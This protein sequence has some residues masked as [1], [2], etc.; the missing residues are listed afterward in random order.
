MHSPL[1]V[2]L[3]LV[4]CAISATGHAREPAPSDD[5]IR[6]ILIRKSIEAYAG[7]CPCPYN[8]ARNGSR[9]GKR[10]AYNRPGGA[11]PLCYPQDIPDEMVARYR[12]NRS[13]VT[14]R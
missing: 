5:D 11:S 8:S 2:V 9:C 3:A 6:Q 7:S 14:A 12:A 1:L 13:A 4:I 10:S